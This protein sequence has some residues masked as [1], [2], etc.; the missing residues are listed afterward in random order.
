MAW[1][2]ACDNGTFRV[3]FRRNDGTIGSIPDFTDEESAGTY[4]ADMKTDQR[5]NVWVDPTTQQTLLGTFAEPGWI[6][7]LDVDQ[8]TE[9]NYRSFLKV[10]IMPKWKNYPLPEITNLKARVWKKELHALGLAPSTV[11]SIMKCFSMLLSDAA[12][13]NLLP[14]NP[15]RK[16][17]RGRRQRPQRR[18]RQI[19]SESDDVLAIADQAALV[20]GPGAALLIVT[21][22]WTG[23]RWGELT[24]L[25]R[26]NVH[27]FDDDTGKIVIDPDF[28]CLHEPCKGAMFLG[29]PKTN[30]SVREVSL[31]PFLVRLL[32]AH[33][34]THAHRHVF[35][36]PDGALHRRS[37]FAR[38]AFRLAA[39]GN[40]HILDAPIR[41]RAVKPGLKFH[42]LRH[43]HKTWMIS[44][45]IPEIAQA[46]RLGHEL[47]DKVQQTYSHV[48]RA[49]EERL[50]DLLQARWEKA[51]AGSATPA[52][53]ST[54]RC[55]A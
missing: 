13:E 20:Y 33:L 53:Q 47:K 32:R 35:V 16:P 31:P 26:I 51:V 48:A 2:E 11:D 38:R 5:R 18:V 6:D 42:G 29:P 27:L 40:T 7:S 54:W 46:L 44:D 25:D 43:S 39:D 34:A 22:A 24:G 1:T 55:A 3:R 23:L 45:G 50:L 4:I 30:S 49:V 41:L 12:D 52:E 21:A 28:G 17:R 14:A 8:R 19:W 15:I 37:N 10:H 9:E 36:T